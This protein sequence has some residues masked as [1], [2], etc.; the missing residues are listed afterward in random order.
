[1]NKLSIILLSLLGL[2]LTTACT[3]EMED[4]SS[5]HTE[6][7]ALV[8]GTIGKSSLQRAT[9]GNEDNISYESFLDGDKIGLFATGGL[10]AENV[11]LT[12]SDGSFKSEELQWKGQNA[13]GIYAYFPHS[14]YIPDKKEINIWRKESPADWEAGFE[15]MLAASNQTVPEGT[16]INLGFTHQFA[17]LIIK[18]GKGFTN[19]TDKKI[20]VTLN[21]S[22]SPTATIHYDG[23]NSY[24]ALQVDAGKD[25]NIL[26]A[27]S[28]NDIDHVIIPVGKIDNQDVNVA[29]ITIANDL[30]RTMNIAYAVKGNPQKNN[31]Y[32]VTVEMRDN[33]AVVSP[34][35]IV[36]WDDESI[37]VE[38]PKGISTPEELKNWVADYNV[39]KKDNFGTYGT[40]NNGTW[41][42][43]LLNDIN[44]DKDFHGI[45]EFTDEFDGQGHTITGLNLKELGGT[46]NLPTGFTRTLSGTIRRLTLKDAIVWGQTEV[47][48]FAGKATSTG[49]IEECQLSGASIIYGTDKVN[50]FVGN[51]E[52]ASNVTGCSKTSTVIVKTK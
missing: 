34:V 2:G 7:T 46:S 30:N 4:A 51:N 37:K 19:A 20:K 21:Q 11:E 28:K 33:Q 31:K 5:T 32:V 27:T 41:T 9:P 10:L 26:D 23:V 12:L 39:N 38:I 29:S 22:V 16:I 42:F 49:K 8:K 50:A 6:K 47:G 44:I 18:R 45:T 24:I 48:A 35:E 25:A 15:D 52:G 14:A 36:R 17:M 40:N 43:R 13:I 3:N 1:M